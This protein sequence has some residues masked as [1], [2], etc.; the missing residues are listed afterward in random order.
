MFLNYA[1]PHK[2]LVHT[3]SND[4]FSELASIFVQ[5]VD[6]GSCDEG[7]DILKVFFLIFQSCFQILNFGEEYNVQGETTSPLAHACP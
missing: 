4:P 6:T 7:F 3:T 2:I 5:V 1:L